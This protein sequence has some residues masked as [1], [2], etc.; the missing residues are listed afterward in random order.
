MAEAVDLKAIGTRP[1]RPDGVEKVTGRANFG[2]DLNLPG[3][4]HG[5]IL[6]SP[7][8]HARIKSI[9]LSGALAVDGVL[10][11]ISGEDI[12]G[13]G[14]LG[15]NVLANEKVLYHGHAVA[16]VAATSA[17]IAEQA[18]DQIQVEYEV[19][20]PVLSIDDAIADGATLVNE[21]QHTN[22][23]TSQPASNIAAITKFERGDI[24]KG[25]AEAAVVAEGEF[26]VPTAHQGYI[27]PHA[28]TATINEEGKA[29]VWCCTQGQFDV[30]SMTANCLDKQVSDIRVIP[31]EIG[32]GFGG[33][34]TIY[35]EP[36]AVKL[37]EISGRPVK[38]VMSREEVF[39]ATGPTSATLCRVKVGAKSDGTI[40]AATAWLAYEAGAY[41]GAP[42]GPGCMSVLAPYELEN[43]KIEGHDVLVNKPKVAA[44]RAPGAPQSMHAMECAI[45]DLARKL[46][47]DP[48]ELRLKNAADE[49]TIA[50]YG[51]QFPAIGLRACLEAAK[52]HPNYTTP[53]A[54]GQ[55]RGV[56]VGFWFNIGMQSSA[57]IRIAENG[58]VTIM[59]G[60]PDIG[61]SRASMCLMAA[62]TLGIPYENINA[63]VGDTEATG[64]CNTTGGS[65]TTFATGMAVIEACEDIIAQC[66]E[67]A[68]LTWDLDV[69]QVD[70]EDGQA[71]P[72]PGVNADV[73]P[74][75]LADIARSAG[76]TG[77]PLLGRASL[78]A[79]GPG[80]SFSV[81]WTDVEVDRETGKVDVMA[82]T[83]VQDAGRAIHPSYV[84]GQ[85]QGGAVQGLGWA[86]NEEYIYD[87]NGVMENAGFLDY[88]VPVTSDMPMIDTQIVEVPN[89]SHP[90]GVRG[91]GETPIVA[92]LAATSNAVRDALGFR[93]N[94]LPLSP[95]RVLAAIDENE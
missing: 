36:V 69:N 39:R 78:N 30:R 92:P 35:L 28:C 9:D 42:V 58:A 8:A 82:F 68:A 49:G 27:E 57:E 11:A 1:V 47:M 21:S 34:T 91:V 20:N 40:T 94:D 44:Y 55:G 43:F 50:P 59:E 15:D 52:V 16:A 38:M 87:A 76:R 88:R 79:Q 3:M 53:P 90:Y 48:I 46:E 2:A 95:P 32:G 86:L 60:S 93:I 64:Y 37:S 12:P 33:K 6:R 75:S 71:V 65:R 24:D 31:S 19:L 61:G 77:G 56:A 10:A 23:D 45:D 22:G 74:L 70:W 26:R 14:D 67:R 62:E 84:E 73:K 17:Y 66:K 89:P 54:E 83:G 63:H 72:K 81:N 29:T 18:L 41:P 13:G 25:F 85:M 80:A 5:K 4:L 7:H 51:P